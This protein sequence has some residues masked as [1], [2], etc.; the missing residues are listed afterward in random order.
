MF[1]IINILLS[2]IETNR[3]DTMEIG[4]TIKFFRTSMNLKQEE[5]FP[6]EMFSSS[7]LS[8][9]ETGKRTLKVEELQVM[10]NQLGLTFDEFSRLT[11]F[12][13]DQ[14]EFVKSFYACAADPKNPEF[15][16]E[17]LKYYDYYKKNKEKSQRHK[18]N[19]ISIVNFF[20]SHYPDEI[21]PLEMIECEKTIN[22]IL[23]KKFLQHYDFT[24]I[25]NT[26]FMFPHRQINQIFDT[27][28]PLFDPDIRSS[29]TL[30]YINRIF[31]NIITINIHNKRLTS[32]MKYISY[33]KKSNKGE[34]QQNNGFKLALRYLENCAKY[35]KTDNLKYLTT[36]E[37][38][39][40]LI[41]ELGNV[42]MAECL[43]S[44]LKMIIEKNFKNSKNLTPQ[45]YHNF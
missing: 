3:G 28:Y 39:I 16:S 4:D 12:D 29:E 17:I 21:K 18:S 19:Y 34:F 40:S 13:K 8:K 38:T 20:T 41:A 45:I 15:K 25:S 1:K 22:Q 10:L 42:Q 23:D 30:A 27:I 31:N 32:A 11:D 24:I 36:A 44:E 7:T 6:V 5:L 33:A 2:K 35:L 14:K 37:E 26:I 9:I 43:S